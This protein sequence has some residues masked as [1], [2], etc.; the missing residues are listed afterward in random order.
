LISSVACFK[1]AKRSR[2]FLW[3]NFFLFLSWSFNLSHI[4]VL[5]FSASL[6]PLWRSSNEIGEYERHPHLPTHTLYQPY[7]ILHI[8]RTRY[9]YLFRESSGLVS[10][11]VREES[12]KTV[13]GMV[14]MS[15]ININDTLS[16]SKQAFPMGFS[17]SDEQ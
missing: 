16:S 2:S 13:L 7:R 3:S 15:R 14:R 5:V 10:R 8:L 1:E 4:H 9:T 17:T 11:E 6:P 12:S